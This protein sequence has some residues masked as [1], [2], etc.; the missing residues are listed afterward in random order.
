[1]WYHQMLQESREY[2]LLLTKIQDCFDNGTN[3]GCEREFPHRLSCLI[4][5]ER[6]STIFQI[7]KWSTTRLQ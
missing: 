7:E 3:G 4:R 2:I 1:M 5:Q 6:A